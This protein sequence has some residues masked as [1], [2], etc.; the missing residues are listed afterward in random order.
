[1]PLPSVA[2]LLSLAVILAGPACS[3]ESA[4]A[5]AATG[6]TAPTSVESRVVEAACGSCMFDMPGSDCS[7]AVR[8]DGQAHYVDGAKMDDFGDAHAADGFCNAI[9]QARVSGR[10]E[11]ERFVATV[12]ELLPVGQ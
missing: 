7:L 4:P 5:P 9:R 12:F 6:S 10:L 11:G 8:I 2:R 1:M 3:R